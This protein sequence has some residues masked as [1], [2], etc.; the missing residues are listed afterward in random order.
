LTEAKRQKNI[1]VDA[2]ARS[3]FS[4]AQIPSLITLETNGMKSAVTAAGYN[5]A[6]TFD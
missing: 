4:S 5:L 2:I 1:G 6:R 3:G